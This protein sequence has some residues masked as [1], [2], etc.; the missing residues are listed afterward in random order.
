M[1]VTRAYKL[2]ISSNFRKK[3]EVRYTYESFLRYVNLWCGKLFFNGNKRFSTEGLGG[4]ANKAQ[5]KACGIIAAQRA[6]VKVTGEKSNIP[7]VKTIGCPAKIEC[8]KKSSFDYWISVE[9][10]FAKP[11]KLPAKSHRKLNHALRDGWKLNKVGEITFDKN[12]QLYVRVFVQKEVDKAKLST[13][14]L[15]CDVGYKNSVARSDRYIG[16]NLSKV[17]K[18]A[19][20]K[21]AQHRK[22]GIK[23]KLVKSRVKQLLDI[24]AK[25]AVGRSKRIGASL[26]VES[27]KILNNL[28]SGKLQSWARNYF[29]N[30]CHVLGKE[31]EVFVWEVNPAYTSQTCSKCGVLDKQSRKN[32]CFRC[33]AC[34]HTDHADINAAINI[35]EMGTLSLAKLLAR[36]SG[37]VSDNHEISS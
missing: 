28:R 24:E 11:V 16:H 21:D 36:R 13:K 19:R 4:L 23:S 35:A 8:S 31:Q 20:E 17:I 12:G 14:T 30:R 29:A 1:L 5:H 2:S 15:G 22:Q 26:I 32:Q 7:I 25:L 33:V 27:P 6:A 3:D 34:G 9:S 10:Q 18:Q 37:N